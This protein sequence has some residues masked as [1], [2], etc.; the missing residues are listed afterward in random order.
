MEQGQIFD[1]AKAREWLAMKRI[2]CAVPGIESVE[3][4]LH[5]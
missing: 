4:L 5:S 1:I 2:H 3:G